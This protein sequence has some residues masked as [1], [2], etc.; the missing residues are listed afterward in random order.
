LVF[1]LLKFIFPFSLL[2]FRSCCC[3]CFN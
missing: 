2:V 3:C 1:L